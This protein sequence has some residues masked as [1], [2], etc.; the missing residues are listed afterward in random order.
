MTGKKT[1]FIVSAMI[2]TFKTQVYLKKSADADKLWETLKKWRCASKNTPEDIK[3]EITAHNRAPEKMHFRAKNGGFIETK[4]ICA[5]GC[6]YWGLHF[7]EPHEKNNQWNTY[8][9]L[10]QKNNQN[11][12]TFETTFDGTVTKRIGRNKPKYFES[13]IKPLIES[14]LPHFSDRPQITDTEEI[15]KYIIDV[16]SGQKQVDMPLVYV[17]YP[18]KKI[19]ADELAEKLFCM[20]EVYVES[21]KCFSFELKEKTDGANAYNGAVGIYWGNRKSFY[22]VNDDDI[23]I[24]RIYTRIADITAV[25]PFSTGAS[26]FNIIQEEHAL[27]Q[28][29]LEAENE[30]IL[31]E[32]EVQSNDFNAKI[33]SYEALVENLKEQI[34]AKDTVIHSLNTELEN[35]KNEFQKFINEFDE[36]NPR[37]KNENEK[38]MAERDAYKRKAEKQYENRP[39]IDIHI[40]CSEHELFPDEIS[41]FI[42]GLIFSAIHKE[43]VD[44][45][46]RRKKDVL[47]SIKKEIEDW[48]FE[49]SSA[50]TFYRRCDERWAAAIKNNQSGH[51]IVKML[52]DYKFSGLVE[53]KHYK[54]IFCDDNRYTT[55]VPKTPGDYRSGKNTL[56]DTKRNCFLIPGN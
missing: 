47:D 10:T 27:K 56:S 15:K 14:D 33:K 34:D 21:D 4:K 7:M 35:K 53:G 32:K 12:L 30:K 1:L 26:W 39:E 16:M 23:T 8:I 31:K 41:D 40:P 44:K 49:K 11:I 20:A 42:K 37:L 45:N 5:A 9:I 50:G 13:Y 22:L 52:K 51:E 25:K 55:T 2:T 3:K 28:K 17:S 18:N 6:A 19:N 24:D 43:G 36:E 54:M 29:I 38:L 48:K 46:A